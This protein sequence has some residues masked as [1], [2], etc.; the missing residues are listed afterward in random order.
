MQSK[1]R[2]YNIVG[3]ISNLGG[4]MYPEHK[5]NDVQKGDSR[6][7]SRN[8]A[9]RNVKDEFETLEIK[10]D[11]S[12]EVSIDSTQILDSLF[13]HTPTGIAILEGPEYR[14]LSI[15]RNLAELNGLSVKDHLGKSLK[16]VLPDAAEDLLPVMRKIMKTGKAIL[17]RKFSITLPKD[18]GRAVHLV[19]YL[20]PIPD[21][22]GKP[23]GIGA[24]VVDITERKIAEKGL[25]RLALAATTIGDAVCVTDKKGNIEFVNSS[26]KRLLGYKE[27]EL[28]GKPI[29]SLY[30]GG[31]RN[32]S[33]QQ[34]LKAL[35]KKKWSGEV[36][37][38]HK[39]G[40]LI[41]T[42]ETASPLIE[43]GQLQGFVCTNTDITDLKHA[44]DKIRQYLKQLEKMVE[45]RTVDLRLEIDEH[46]VTFMKLE[47]SQEKLRNLA[48]HL[49]T[50]REEERS[51]LAR[52]I[53]DEL[54]QSL[55]AI[56]MDLSTLDVQIPDKQTILIEKLKSMVNI[57]NSS[58]STVRKIS[59]KLRPALL[60]DLG[61]I[62][63]I[64]WQVNDFR[65]RSKIKCII[66]V[67]SKEIEVE[68]ERST[69]IFRILQESLTNVLR[70]AKATKVNVDIN[71][72]DGC[73]SSKR[74]GLTD[75]LN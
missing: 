58:L 32:R 10:K 28:L 62:P 21:K 48:R 68:G 61:L 59:S 42:L 60:D 51:G 20:F 9:S 33:L 18:S 44:E 47:K 30:P 16:E 37:L 63:S 75:A 11:P 24:I 5:I 45:K 4:S 64:K 39:N 27:D 25:Q 65:E 73:R 74:I 72:S 29:S 49:Q 17:G 1:V 7:T 12:N 67:P 66:N 43:D 71:V 56:K 50:V 22:H 19:D 53:H 6:V 70:H 8:K 35:P 13:K 2:L 26:L 52:E 14:Y 3:I 38:K 46:K 55:T 23:M 36:E 41:P 15:N 40:D 31:L 69:A 34:I 57:V 54:G